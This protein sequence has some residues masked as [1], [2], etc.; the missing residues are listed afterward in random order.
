MLRLGTELCCHGWCVVFCSCYQTWYHA[1]A[2]NYL[3][4]PIGRLKMRALQKILYVCI[5]GPHALSKIPPAI[6]EVLTIDH[7]AL[8][9]TSGSSQGRL[10]LDDELS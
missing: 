8:V 6:R 1:V 4:K 10:L 2:K 9:A 7:T 5:Y 3:G